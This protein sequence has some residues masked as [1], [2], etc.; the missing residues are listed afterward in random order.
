MEWPNGH[1]DHEP[2]HE[3]K[4]QPGLSVLYFHQSFRFSCLGFLECF[5]EFVLHIPHEIRQG[6]GDRSILIGIGEDDA[7]QANQRQE[8]S[9]ERIEEELARGI[10]PSRSHPPPANE[11]E[12]RNQRDFEEDVKE[13]HIERQKSPDSTSL[14]QEHPAIK[15]TLTFLNGVPRNQY[16]R[17]EHETRKSQKPDVQAIEPQIELDARTGLVGSSLRQAQ[18]CPVRSIRRSVFLVDIVWYVFW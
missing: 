2:S 9:R 8:A 11:E 12:S 6:K 17:D 10:A 18:E 14:K 15:G 5:I 4:E 1:L 16:R 7:N 13:N 3:C